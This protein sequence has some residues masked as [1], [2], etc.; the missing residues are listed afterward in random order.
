MPNSCC[1]CGSELTQTTIAREMMLGTR[2]EFTYGLCTSCGAMQLLD[3]PSDLGRYYPREYYAFAPRR[4]TGAGMA[5]RRLR[6]RLA[7][8]PSGPVGRAVAALVPHAATP[9]F[10]HMSLPRTA[11]I[12][13]VGCRGQRDGVFGYFLAAKESG[14]QAHRIMFVSKP[15]QGGGPV[16]S[17]GARRQGDGRP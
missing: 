10:G 3:V 2:E 14:Y 16:L 8:A 15:F 13:D 11:R 17:V 7:I 1:I 4:R 5:L 9:W 12:L 6:N